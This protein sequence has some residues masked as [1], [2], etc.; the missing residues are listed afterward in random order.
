MTKASD[1]LYQSFKE[2]LDANTP[3]GSRLV[4]HHDGYIDIQMCCDGRIPDMA[5]S[6]CRDPGHTGRCYSRHKQVYFD[7]EN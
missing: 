6:C 7:R 2:W 4:V 5:Y 3:E 1:E